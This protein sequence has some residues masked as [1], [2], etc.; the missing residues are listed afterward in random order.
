MEKRF[1][2][3]F[4]ESSTFVL[5]LLCSPDKQDKL[6]EN[7]LQYPFSKLRLLLVEHEASADADARGQ[8]SINHLIQAA[9]HLAWLVQ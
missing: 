9:P 8:F 3:M 2:K 6:S 5:Q 1:R 4:S 7:C